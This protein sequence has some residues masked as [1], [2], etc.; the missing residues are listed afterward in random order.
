MHDYSISKSTRRC[1][2]RGRGLE[3]D[4]S[5]VSV[6]MA[7][8]DD[9]ARMDIAAT[10]WTGPSQG[11]IGWWRNKMPAAAARK[12]RPAP[13]GVLLD[14]LSDLL[15][16][17]G[18]EALAYLL[19]LLLVRRRVL[20]EDQD[21][22]AI[23]A[24]MIEATTG[25]AADASHDPTVAPLWNLVCPADGRQWN[26]PVVVPT[27]GSPNTNLSNTGLADNASAVLSQPSMD[28]LQAELKTLLFT[29]E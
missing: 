21:P 14:T 2:I 17:P 8:G 7:K 3:P 11:T 1:A 26:V 20:Q 5:Y 6:I 13:S 28:E 27:A 29:D 18:K 15:Q 10:S 19:A 16:R 4:E 25:D 23:E 9:V 24:T 12:L 22:L